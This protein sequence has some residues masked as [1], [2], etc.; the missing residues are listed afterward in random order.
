[1]GGDR[2]PRI[3]PSCSVSPFHCSGVRKM[4]QQVME[5]RPAEP[6]EREPTRPAD[7][8]KKPARGRRALIGLAIAAVLIALIGVGL[9]WLQ[10]RHY[11]STDDAFVETRFVSISPQVAGA[12]V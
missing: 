1:M 5:N 8:K 7:K 4:D 9:W 12:I 2:K 10:A 6:A 11:E 3:T